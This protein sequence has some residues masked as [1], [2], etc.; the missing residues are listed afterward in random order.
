MYC[1][2]IRTLSTIYIERANPLEPVPTPRRAVLP[3][4]FGQDAWLIS[5]LRGGC[6]EATLQPP[7]N[8]Q[9]VSS[10]MPALVLSGLLP[11]PAN[12]TTCA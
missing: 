12:A 1:Q 11:G 7:C 5:R 6:K 3:P 2:Y 8:L 10:H 9:P 4:R